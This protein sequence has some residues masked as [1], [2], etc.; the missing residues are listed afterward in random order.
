[1][2]A[3]L[4]KRDLSGLS[5]LDM[6]SG[7]GVLA[8]VAAKRGAVHVDAVDIDDWAYE[9]S[10]E[11]IAENGVQGRVT[12]LLGMCPPSRENVTISSW[13]ISTAT[14]CSPTCR[15]THRRSGRGANS[16]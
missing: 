16:S 8:I 13:P 11:N 10:R 15:V 2:T 3:E 9:N 7:T 1:M 12:P 5:G 6:G 4:M 14:S